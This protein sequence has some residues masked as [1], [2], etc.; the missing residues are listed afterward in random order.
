MVLT[1][2]SYV[3]VFHWVSV[4]ENLYSLY[5]FTVTMTYAIMGLPVASQSPWW[6]TLPRHWLAG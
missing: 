5:K 4:T 2:S 3:W 6:C 1:P